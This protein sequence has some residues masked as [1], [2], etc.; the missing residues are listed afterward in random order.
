MKMSKQEKDEAA[1]WL[2]IL[3]GSIGSLIL[4]GALTAIIG[5]GWAVVSV[6]GPI[7]LAAFGW[8]VKQ[9]RK[10]SEDAA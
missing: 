5:F 7:S 1:V 4:C 6:F 9:L 2:T 8:G 10:K 3:G